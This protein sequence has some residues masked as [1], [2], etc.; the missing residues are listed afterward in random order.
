MRCP[1]VVVEIGDRR[2]HAAQ[3]DRQ[4]GLVDLLGREV[5]VLEVE[6]ERPHGGVGLGRDHHQSTARPA[7]HLGHTVMVDDAHRLAEHG[8]ADAVALDQL[9]LGTEHLAHRPAAGDDL[10]LDPLGE[11]LT[12]LASTDGSRLLLG[13]GHSDKLLGRARPAR[14]HDSQ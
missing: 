2:P 13:L 10:L 3:L 7:S 9:G 12:Q 1:A 5:E 14:R 8:P 4:P 6:R 11:L